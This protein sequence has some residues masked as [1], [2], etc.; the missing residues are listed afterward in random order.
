MT[1]RSPPWLPLLALLGLATACGG[2]RAPEP[3]HVLLITLDTTRAD[4][5]G[6]YGETRFETPALDALASEGVVFE[7]C[8]SAAAAS[9]GGSNPGE[10][11]FQAIY[12]GSRQ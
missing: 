6:A 8:S 11:E 3:R 7:R 12:F 2:D 1:F 10:R 4:H 9:G 5:L